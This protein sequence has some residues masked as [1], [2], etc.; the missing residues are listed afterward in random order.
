MNV[1]ML[2]NRFLGYVRREFKTLA[3]YK[4]IYEKPTKLKMWHPL[5][6][7]D[8]G[9]DLKVNEQDLAP[10][11]VVSPT[12]QETDN[13]IAKRLYSVEFMPGKTV[14]HIKKQQ[15]QQL[16]QR[17]QL[18]NG[19]VETQIAHLTVRIQNLQKYIEL[20]HRDAKTR[21]SLKH[22]VDRRRQLLKHLR[23]WDYRKFE[24]ILEKLNLE[25]RPEPVGPKN[26]TRKNAMR[27]MAS[28]VSERIIDRKLQEYKTKLEDQLVDFYAEK[29]KALEFIKKE[30][31]ELDVPPTVTE[32]DIA[33]VK[34][35][36][37][38]AK[39]KQIEREKAKLKVIL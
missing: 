2:R 34:R 22:L 16:V 31:A 6:T 9:L 4:I 20:M 8:R 33:E 19:S 35:K 37:D 30:E 26:V 1:P 29:L 39:Q 18:D 13:E 24:W 14:Q 7:G 23:D 21:I 25:Y 15:V 32:E 17:H 12:L 5:K 36:A 3:D 28:K 38:S 10:K 27:M 11:Y